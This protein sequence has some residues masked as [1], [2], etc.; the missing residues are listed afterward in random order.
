MA[1]SKITKLF[2]FIDETLDYFLSKVEGVN[3]DRYFADR[4]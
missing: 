3:R 4:D 2:A 1:D